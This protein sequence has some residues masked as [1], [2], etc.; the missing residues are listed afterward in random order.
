MAIKRD[1]TILSVDSNNGDVTVLDRYYG[2][3]LCARISQT[4]INQ[5][6]VSLGPDGYLINLGASTVD[7]N[8]KHQPADYI[9]GDPLDESFKKIGI[10][11]AAVAIC[12]FIAGVFAGMALVDILG[13]IL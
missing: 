2:A 5:I 3:K 11:G 4:N 6:E 7:K 10:G 13:G 12:C 8:T 9:V 1:I